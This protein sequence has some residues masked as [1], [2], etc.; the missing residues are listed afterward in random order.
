MG[1]L[2]TGRKILVVEDQFMAALE[3]K[4]MIQE[5]GGTVVGP[6]ARLEQAL[7]LARSE[8]LDAGLLDYALDHTTSEPIADEL[9]S[10]AVPVIFITG[11]A[12]GSLPDRFV[13]T[14]RLDK[15]VSRQALERALR[16]VLPGL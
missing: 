15:P 7:R 11:Y 1:Q 5:R 4:D 8:E 2:L 12:A 13:S 16:S 3:M 6:V 9:I 14:P 10:Q